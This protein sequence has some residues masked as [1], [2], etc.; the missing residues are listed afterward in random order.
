MLSDRPTHGGSWNCSC[1]IGTV[2]WPNILLR[3]SA[4]RWTQQRSKKLTSTTS[5]VASSSPLSRNW[6]RKTAGLSSG[7]PSR[8]AGRSHGFALSS[9][10]TRNP[11]C[12]PTIISLTSPTKTSDMTDRRSPCST[13]AR[14]VIQWS[15]T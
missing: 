1:T 10:R 6:L 5:S 14:Q 3:I 2:G 4:P 8:Q 11:T 12:S 7:R 15:Q 9:G 13:Y